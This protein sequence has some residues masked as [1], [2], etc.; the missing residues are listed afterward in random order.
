MQAAQDSKINARAVDNTANQF[1]EAPT[2]ALPGSRGLVMLDSQ[3]HICSCSDSLAALAG[4]AP[5][6]LLGQPVK[7]LLP[8]LPVSDNTPGYN[9]AFAAFHAASGRVYR[10]RLIK[11]DGSAIAVSVLLNVLKVNRDY[12]F[13]LEVWELARELPEQPELPRTFTSGAVRPQ[14]KATFLHCA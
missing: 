3:G 10:S 6:K 7:T 13:K 9:V 5:L 1:E 12:R 11:S 2:P 4:V 8:G 14:D